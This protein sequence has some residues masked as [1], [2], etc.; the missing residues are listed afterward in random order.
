MMSEGKWRPVNLMDIELAVV[1]LDE[2]LNR[3]LQFVTEPTLL[4]PYTSMVYHLVY[5]NHFQVLGKP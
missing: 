3:S 4:L 5:I 2:E 1:N